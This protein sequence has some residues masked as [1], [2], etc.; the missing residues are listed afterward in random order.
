MSDRQEEIA[1]SAEEI[2]NSFV[3]ATRDIPEVKETYFTQESFNIVREDG[4]PTP[5]EELARLRRAF[6]FN[7]PGSDDSGNLLV[8]VAGWVGER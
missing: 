7:A 1:K 6:L 4:C 5:P 2:V 8:E 3:E